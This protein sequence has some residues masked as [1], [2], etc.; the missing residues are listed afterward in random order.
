MKTKK[1]EKFINEEMAW[2]A[3]QSTQTMYMKRGFYTVT[4]FHPV[5]CMVEITVHFDLQNFPSLP[6]GYLYTEKSYSSHVYYSET[7]KSPKR[8]RTL[9]LVYRW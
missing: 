6:A 9:E 2:M 8:V 5:A 7:L 1:A 4:T 3:A